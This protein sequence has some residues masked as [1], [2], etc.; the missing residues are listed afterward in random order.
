MKDLYEL[1]TI[2][3]VVLTLAE[4]GLVIKNDGV[5]SQAPLATA[6][7]AQKDKADVNAV[8]KAVA[9][10][11]ARKEKE[12]AEEAA[13]KERVAKEALLSLVK[14]MITIPDKNFKMGKYEVTQAQ[15]PAVMGENPSE[16]KGDLNPVECV[17]WDDC[18]VF[19]EKLNA[20]P[21][22]K[23]SGLTFRLPTEAEWEY[24]CRAGSTGDYCWLAD[25]S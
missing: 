4:K 13:R 25:G 20:L 17:S 12:A 1:K 8:E 9:E 14:D 11:A 3:G 16:F 5:A 24:A 19:L 10:E 22:V 23:A 15:W 6:E 2:D 7:A 21:E 18:K